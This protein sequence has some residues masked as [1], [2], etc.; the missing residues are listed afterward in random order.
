MN[1]REILKNQSLNY[2]ENKENQEYL[3]QVKPNIPDITYILGGKE[4]KKHIIQNAKYLFFERLGIS[5]DCE[6]ALDEALD[7]VIENIKQQLTI[8]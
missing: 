6:L 2:Q 3:N 1:W 8:K 4:I 7:Y 5:D